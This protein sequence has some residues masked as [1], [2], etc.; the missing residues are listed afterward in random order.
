MVCGACGHTEEAGAAYCS[1]CGSP[2]AITAAGNAAQGG[3]H[4]AGGTGFAPVPGP[5]TGSGPAA[6]VEST[7][8]HGPAATP[9]RV[10]QAQRPGSGVRPAGSTPVGAGPAVLALGALSIL[11]AII[12]QMI[13]LS[14]DGVSLSASQVNT[15]CQSTLG[16][17]GQ[18]VSGSFGDN[19]PSAVCGRAATIEDWKGITLWLGIALV[20]AGIG[21]LGRRAAL[22]SRAASAGTL[23]AQQSPAAKLAAAE[24]AEANAARLRA[25]AAQMQAQQMPSA[26]PPEQPSRPQQFPAAEPRQASAAQFAQQPPIQLPGDP[27]GSNR[28]AGPWRG[29]PD[30]VHQTTDVE[31]RCEQ[32]GGPQGG[33][34]ERRAPL[35]ALRR[36]AHVPGSRVFF[37]LLPAETA[38][39]RPAPVNVAP[40]SVTPGDA[41]P[42]GAEVARAADTRSRTP[43]AA[44]A[45][46]PAPVRPPVA[47]SDSIQVELA[48]G[49]DRR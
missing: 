47:P 44:V 4:P 24:R 45:A 20:A 15:I 35:R 22:T 18:S 25:Q 34:G 1:S 31:A 40:V 14:S 41:A 5:W 13:K 38:S 19:S 7:L 3:G 23:A 21:A 11:T 36:P 49:R 28:E 9:A 42:P 2:L 6:P 48:W 12:L 46:V 10:G 16:Q 26:P 27:A 8:S 33:P 30:A 32:R 29:Q 17:L 43:A 37:C 39:V